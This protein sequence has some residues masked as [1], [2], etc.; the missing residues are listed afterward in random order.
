MTLDLADPFHN[1]YYVDLTDVL[2]YGIPII[3]DDS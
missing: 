3:V 2:Y 1:F